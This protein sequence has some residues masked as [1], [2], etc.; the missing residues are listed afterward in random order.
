MKALIFGTILLMAGGCSTVAK[1]EVKKDVL[2]SKVSD[3]NGLGQSIEE[4]INN[5]KNLSAEDKAKLRTIINENKTQAEKLSEES[6]RY[7]SVLVKELFAESPS[8]K[9]INIIKK[10][11]KRIESL[12]L[13]NT[14]TAVEKISAIL[15]KGPEKDKYRESLIFD[16]SI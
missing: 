9:K 7:R 13:K 15:N 14:L 1:K 2:E 11:I 5:S 12:K 16:R 6:Y 10:D 3:G 4:L 8:K